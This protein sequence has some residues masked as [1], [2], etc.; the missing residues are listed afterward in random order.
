[1]MGDVVEL[2]PRKQGAPWTYADLQGQTPL[3]N[4]GVKHGPRGK[5]ELVEDQVWV[6]MVSPNRLWVIA[7]KWVVR[8]TFY[9]H[10]VFLLAYRGKELRQLPETLLRSTM[11]VW[12]EWHE[13]K[14]GY[15]A[16]FEC[17]I[18]NDPNSPWLGNP[19]ALEFA[20]RF[21]LDAQGNRIRD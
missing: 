18:K 8:K 20:Q 7:E 19:Q 12:D 13:F 15:K 6:E 16:R 3:R 9:P 10:N 11:R 17:C 14:C 1:V 21:G 4:A 5:V 2:F